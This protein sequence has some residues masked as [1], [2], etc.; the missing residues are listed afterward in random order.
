MT[1]IIN[2][3]QRPWSPGNQFA[4]MIFVEFLDFLWGSS[5]FRGTRSWRAVVWLQ[6]PCMA[7]NMKRSPK[8]WSMFFII[9]C[10]L[11]SKKFNNQKRCQSGLH[12]TLDPDNSWLTFPDS[13][14]IPTLPKN[15]L[16]FGHG[17]KIS[18][19]LDTAKNL[20]SG[21]LRGTTNSTAWWTSALFWWCYGLRKVIKPPDE[22][23]LKNSHN[24]RSYNFHCDLKRI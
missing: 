24:E 13:Q 4:S 12:P 18:W 1:K 23:Y 9:T 14:K 2:M 16:I 20:I 6:G 15:K 3:K 19:H 10:V 5:D 7:L 11:G 21:M 22:L 17:Q 8:L